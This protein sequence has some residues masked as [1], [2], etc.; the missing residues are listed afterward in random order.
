M[1]R[2]I[3]VGGGRR[4]RGLASCAMPLRHGKG[5]AVGSTRGGGQVVRHPEASPTA[6]A[7]WRGP[8]GWRSVQALA[9]EG[10]AEQPHP[11][12]NW[13]R[14][15]ESA[16]LAWAGDDVYEWALDRRAWATSRDEVCEL[17]RAHL[18]RARPRAPC[19][20]LNVRSGHPASVVAAVPRRREKTA[21]LGP[22][23]GGVG[24]QLYL[25]SCAKTRTRTGCAHRK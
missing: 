12:E 19:D 5:C 17:V 11:R 23:A 3:T 25:S 14:A 22:P 16:A 24:G 21:S 20:C 7:D 6:P 8:W 18:P 1:P 15:V 4:R 10:A 2:S 9:G 13:P